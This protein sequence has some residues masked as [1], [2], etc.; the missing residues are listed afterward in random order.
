[1]L[2]TIVRFAATPVS[3]RARMAEQREQAVQAKMSLAIAEIKSSHKGRERF[4]AI[5]ALYEKH[6]YHPIHSMASLLPLL[7]QIPILLAALLLLTSHEQIR[8][9]SFIFLR[10]LGAPDRLLSLDGVGAVNLL[11][12]LLTLIA[13]TEAV[14]KQGATAGSRAKFFVV[15]AVIALLIYPLPSGVCLYWLTSNI[16]SG[17][18]E[19]WRARAARRSSSASLGTKESG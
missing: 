8:G 11:P 9:Q 7:L 17:I 13:I 14:F 4:E 12:L 6:G 10:D 15:S 5:E 2:S 1:M 18:S 3:R 19:L 16:W